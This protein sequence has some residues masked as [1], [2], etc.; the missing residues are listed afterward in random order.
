MY[1]EVSSPSR[2]LRRTSLTLSF[3]EFKGFLPD[4]SGCG[5]GVT[6]EDDRVTSLEVR[7]HLEHSVFCV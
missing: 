6:Q 5:G 7:S 1:Q 3:K 2:S 4:K